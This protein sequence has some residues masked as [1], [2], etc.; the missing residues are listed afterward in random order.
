MSADPSQLSLLRLD[1]ACL[2]FVQGHANATND[3]IEAARQ[4]GL[5]LK[6]R[7]AH[8][9]SPGQWDISMEDGGFVRIV[10]VADPMQFESPVLAARFL[11]RSAWQGLSETV[12]QDALRD[13]AFDL[14]EEIRR[15]RTWSITSDG[16]RKWAASR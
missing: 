2:A 12:T 16:L 5:F 1:S 14:G 6:S 8:I 7:G 3:L 13:L 10:G 15:R 11:I 9:R 4:R